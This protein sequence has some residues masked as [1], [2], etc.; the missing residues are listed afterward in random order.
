MNTRDAIN[1][2]KSS[3]NILD[4]IGDDIFIR[5]Q[6]HEDRSPSFYVYEDTS[7]RTE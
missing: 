6:F 5:G 2:I 3:L 4:F 1:A 7:T